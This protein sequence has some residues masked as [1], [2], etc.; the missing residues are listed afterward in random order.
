MHQKPKKKSIK[1]NAHKYTPIFFVNGRLFYSIL[2]IYT[3]QN[4]AAVSGILGVCFCV[5]KNVLSL[6]LFFGGSKIQSNDK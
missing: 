3:S 6:S 5:T 1:L 2:F 4:E